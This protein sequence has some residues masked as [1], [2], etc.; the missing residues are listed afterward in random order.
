MAAEWII[1]LVHLLIF[2]GMFI[3]KNITLGKK[4]KKK[5]RGNNIEAT[6]S[7]IYFSL[8]IVVALTISIFN[9]SFG[10]LQFLPDSIA[11]IAGLVLLF[12]S[13]V[14]S[15]ASLVNL[16]DSWRVGVLEDQ[17]TKLI[18]SGIY[19]FT[20]N[21]YFVSYLLMF[22]GYTVILQNLLLL[23]LTIVAMFFVHNMIL[24]EEKYLHTVHAKDFSDYINKVPRYIFI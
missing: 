1:I 5:I 16:G 18:T 13:L 3:T 8:I 12:I 7:I 15:G 6:I 17:K 2:Q 21:P 14:I 23:G 22:V 4:I 9:I 24:K 20:R 19:R 11:I 10:K